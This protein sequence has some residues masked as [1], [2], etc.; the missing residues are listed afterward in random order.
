MSE[1]VFRLFVSSPGDVA[2]ERARA[3]AVI[4]KLN[5]EFKDRARFDAEFWQDH[6]YSAHETFQKQIPE[7][8]DFDLV[9]AIFR[10]RL[11]SPLPE[12]FR[13]LPGGEPYPSGT[14]YEVLSAIAKRRDGA[15]LPDIYVFRYPRAPQVS[16]D[17][18]D[19]AEIDKQWRALM[20]FF[21]RWFETP[22]G[23]FVAGFQAYDNTDDFAERVEGCL[24]QWL[25]KRGIAGRETWDRAR[26]GSP[27][28]G[29]AA[30]E[31]DRERVF[32]GREIS[33]RQA[34]ERLRAA[35]APFLLI[36][37]ASGAGKSSLLRAGLLPKLTR[38]GAV[39]EIDLLRPALMTPGLDPFG[40]LAGALL[41]PEALGPELSGGRFA[42]KATLAQA[43]RGDHA[44]AAARIGEALDKAAE[45]RREAAHF[46]KPR[47][48]RVLIGV[49]QG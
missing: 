44:T 36:L 4:E 42:D 39:P 10:A 24:R 25:A 40:E 2:A 32:F 34:I 27:F 35:K 38:P 41:A 20:G 28:P 47:P 15:P 45:A 16:L 12:G 6:F 17:A 22:S 8:A 18:A 13:T 19:F 14:A 37:G 30:F 9:V 26:L 11:G 48:A 33:I 1:T 46:E 5:T 29:L 49:D 31:A 43:L 3:E 23:Q 7:A 21:E